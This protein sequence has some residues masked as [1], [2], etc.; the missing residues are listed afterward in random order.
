MASD[1]AGADLPENPEEVRPLGTFPQI[2]IDT[3]RAISLTGKLKGV[4]VL[5]SGARRVVAF[6]SDTDAYAKF[7]APFADKA[8]AAAWASERF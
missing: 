2:I 8:K 5:G 3:L 7:T 1:Q 6:P 4:A